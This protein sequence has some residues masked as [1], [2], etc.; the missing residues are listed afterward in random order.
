M[1]KLI[2]DGIVFKFLFSFFLSFPIFCLP[3]CAIAS[4]WSNFAAA[5]ESYLGLLSTA[6]AHHC[7]LGVFDLGCFWGCCKL[8]NKTSYQL[9]CG[10]PAASTL[11]ASQTHNFC[12]S[13][14]FCLFTSVPDFESGFKFLFIFFFN[15]IFHWPAWRTDSD[16]KT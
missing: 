14:Q 3:L 5:S 9:P 11:K 8:V 12:L 13:H 10:S 15:F 2:S 16:T 7:G 4:L 6:E 1:S